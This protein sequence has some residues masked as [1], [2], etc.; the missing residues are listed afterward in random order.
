MGYGVTRKLSGFNAAKEIPRRKALSGQ[1][2]EGD[3]YVKTCYNRKLKTF[4]FLRK[5]DAL[6]SFKLGLPNL[7]SWPDYGVYTR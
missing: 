1:N 7:S 2:S 4:I 6:T 5:T 3:R